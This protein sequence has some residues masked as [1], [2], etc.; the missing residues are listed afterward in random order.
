MLKPALARG[1]M[2]CIGATTLNEYKK[3]VERDSA[4]ERRF[5]SIKVAEPDDKDTLC[6]LNG[7]KET[8]E[9]HHK[10]T[11]SPEAVELCVRLSGRYITDRYFPDKAI[12]V[13]DEAGSR[14]RLKNSIRPPEI[15]K[16]ETEI[17]ELSKSKDDMV[18]QQEYEKAAAVRDE[19]NRK[20]EALERKLTEWREKN[21]DFKITIREDD[22][23]AVIS[24]WTGIPLEKLEEQEAQKLLRMEEELKKFL[25]GQDEAVEKICRAVRRSRTGFRSMT[26][27]TGS[28]IFLGPTGVGKTELAK[29]LAEFLFGNKDKLYR[30]DM[31]EYMESHSVSKLIGSPPGYIGYEEGGNLTE[32]VR[33]NP[34][35]VILFDEMEKA[36]RDVFNILL[37]IMEEGTLSDALGHKVDFKDTIVIMTSNVGGRELHKHGKLGFE[38]VEGE[39]Q[40]SKNEMVSDQLKKQ[41]NPEFLN[42]VDEI[43]YFK[44]L[45]GPE[46]RKIIKILLN[47]INDRIAEKALH[48]SMSKK[49]YDYIADIGFDEKNGAR[50]LRRV[51]QREVEDWLAVEM[52]KGSLKE[53]SNVKIDYKRK[54]LQY[55][56]TTK[57]KKSKTEKDTDTEITPEEIKEKIVQSSR[58]LSKSS[59]D[60]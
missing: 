30:M 49:V 10:V 33:R 57:P 27:P 53:N 39:K 11:F 59:Q 29:I 42:R 38:D 9:A 19:V 58:E 50:P 21:N 13:M 6:I 3:Y 31:S 17:Q 16:M 45:G 8:Y 43:I 32:Y 47:E 55:S 41:F 35:S 44:P 28:F 46:I 4:L 54:K 56:V 18:K 2:Q 34:Y 14:A 40:E 7:L 60:N 5:Q 52:L 25:V 48:V 22:I 24:S 36:H 15:K 51:L 23:L 1:E 37:Q 12:D 26:R 20:K